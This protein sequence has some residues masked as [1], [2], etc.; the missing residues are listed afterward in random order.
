ML[1]LSAVLIDGHDEDDDHGD[2]KGQDQEYDE[3]VRGKVAVVWLS[4]SLQT[5]NLI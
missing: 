5:V 3:D 1:G 4:E 2:Q